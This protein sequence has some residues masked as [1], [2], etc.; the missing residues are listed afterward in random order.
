MFG[1]LLGDFQEKQKAMQAQLDEIK[2][3]E[4]S[5]D[6]AISIELTANRYIH[7]ISINFSKIDTESPDQLED[8]LVVT[9][10]K[11][12]EKAAIEAE[13]VSKSMINDILPSGMGGLSDLFG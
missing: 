12:M 8:L 9:L 1:D 11:A 2:I 10:N 6:E 7:N 5:A 3:K 13:K 4:S